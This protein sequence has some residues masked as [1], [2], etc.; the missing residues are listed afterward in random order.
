MT[1]KFVAFFYFIIDVIE[2]LANAMHSGRSPDRWNFNIFK[3][4]GIRRVLLYEL[5]FLII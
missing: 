3:N 5:C 4:F 2:V 1:H